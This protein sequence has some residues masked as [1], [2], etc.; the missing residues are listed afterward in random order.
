M[1][2]LFCLSAE[3]LICSFVNLRVNFISWNFDD[4]NRGGVEGAEKF[5]K[6]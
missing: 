4:V 5:F 3:G 1:N 2:H 6:G